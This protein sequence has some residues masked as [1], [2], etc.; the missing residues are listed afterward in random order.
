MKHQYLCVA[1]FVLAVCLGGSRLYAAPSVG[2]DIFDLTGEGTEESPFLINS[3]S[4]L[5]LVQHFVATHTVKTYGTYS[6]TEKNF[7]D[8]KY[9]RLTADIHLQS[10]QV[11]QDDGQ[12]LPDTSGLS[13]WS[14]IGSSEAAHDFCGIFDGDG[15]T[16]YGVFICDSTAENQGLFGYI[17]GGG[18][19]RNVRLADSFVLGTNAVGGIC[20]KLQNGTLYRCESQASVVGTGPSFQGGGIAGSHTSSGASIDSCKNAGFICGVPVPSPDGGMWNCGTG[21][22]CGQTSA[23]VTRCV[24]EGRVSSEY[25]SPAGGISGWHTGS[26]TISD[27]LNSGHVSSTAS[28]SVGGIVGSNWAVIRNCRNAGVVEATGKGSSMGGIVGVCSYNSQVYDSVNEGDMTS[29]A[30]SVFVGGVVGSMSGGR[31]YNTYYTPKLYR[32]VNRGAITTT[33][34]LSLAGGISGNNYCAEIHDSEN[35]GHVV[36]ASLAGGIVPQCR[37]YSNIYGCSNTG[38]VV[39]VNSTGGI[40]GDTNSTVDNCWNSGNVGSLNKSSNAGGIVGYTTSSVSGCYNT[41]EI[42]TMKRG[43]GIAGYNSSQASVREC[44]NAGTVQAEAESALLGGIG[45]GNGTV[46]NCYNVG[47]IIAYGDNSVVGGV[48]VNVWVSYDSHGNRS[49]STAENCFNMGEVLSKGS[50]GKVGNIAGSYDVS[51]AS[52]LIKNCYYLVGMLR[53][54]GFTDSDEGNTSL[55]PLGIDEFRSLASRLN[56]NRDWW[57]ESPLPFLQGYYRPVLQCT[58][59]QLKPH[60]YTVTTMSGDSVQIDMGAPADNTVFV[61]DE[62]GLVLDAFNVLSGGVVRRAMLVDGQDFSVDEPFRALSLSYRRDSIPAYGMATLPF[63]VDGSDLPLGSLLLTPVEVI[64]GTAL[65]ADT[66][67]AVK[68]GQPFLFQSS[69]DVT[70]WDILKS[71]VMVAPSVEAEGLLK[72]AFCMTRDLEDDCYLPVADEAVFRRAASSDVL[73]PFRAYLQ[74]PGLTADFLSL[75]NQ[76]D[77]T[78]GIRVSERK[79]AVSAGHRN[80]TV[81]GVQGAPVQVHTVSGV[82]LYSVGSVEDVVDIPVGRS[83]LYFVT[84]GTNTS[85]VLVK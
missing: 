14:P 79:C 4:D 54:N 72:G 80:I 81:S 84:V 24:N 58:R 55:V 26:G 11:L 82:M 37:Y 25:F 22:I 56:A 62:T 15:H 7:S 10:Q 46:A 16:V 61:T 32:C 1:F 27:C 31:D 73:P 66:I 39:G 45:G 33:H 21:G 52:S 44:Y 67:G 28:V 29:D 64:G 69:A 23:T 77:I 57:D 53:G 8:G 20:G 38:A 75:V 65:R 41:G 74:I 49:G 6:M 78:T 50:N 18:I 35:H 40:V 17:S 85:R 51:S 48:T 71:D 13:R 36:S 70:E 83:G 19:V 43:G 63:A 68:A 59:N 5:R 76:T 9:F 30:D 42:N 47:R 2:D 34:D 60:Y 3:A 12:L